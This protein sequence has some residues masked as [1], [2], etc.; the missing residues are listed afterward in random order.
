MRAAPIQFFALLLPLVAACTPS[1]N[2]REVTPAGSHL[3]LTFPCKPE[4]AARDVAGLHQGLAKCDA[5]GASFALSWSGL[6]DPREAPEALK[7]MRASLAARLQAAA[8][9]TKPFVVPGMAPQDEALQVELN[10]SRHARVATFARGEAVYELLL[11][12][13]TPIRQAAWEGFAGMVK[14]TD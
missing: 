1:L 9:G 13:D 7:E 6:R 11:I 14:F 4:A 5:D 3:Q 12:S 8:G 10:G 2:W